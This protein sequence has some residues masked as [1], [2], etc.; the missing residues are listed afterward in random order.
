MVAN[1]LIGLE[2]IAVKAAILGGKEVLAVYQTNDFQIKL[3]EDVS[4][5]TIADINSHQVIAECLTNTGIPI[6]S[7]EGEDI[8]YSVRSS[9]N[10]LWVVDPLDGTKEFISRNGEFSINIA[11]VEDG[12][13]VLGVILH[14]VKGIVYVGGPGKGLKIFSLPND[15]LSQD[16]DQVMNDLIHNS[17]SGQN[18]LSPFT[19]VVSKSHF[20]AETNHLIEKA[21]IVFGQV[22]KV[23]IGSAL[24]QCLVANGLAHFYPRIGPTKE[25]DTA[26]GHALVKSTGGNILTWPECKELSY[27]RCCL[28]NPSFI[29]YNGSKKALEFV[30]YLKS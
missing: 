10:R 20:D 8:P 28:T 29:C 6:L 16:I 11:L 12:L 14:P 2:Y 30:N 17:P 1:Q 24:K 15:W 21:E 4:P 26:A 18:H 23:H 3:K 7:E 22:T 27:N 5:V 19:I 9:W 25:W 13:P